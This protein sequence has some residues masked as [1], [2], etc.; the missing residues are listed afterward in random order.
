MSHFYVV[1]KK[2]DNSRVVRAAQPE[3]ARE[4][5]RCVAAGGLLAAVMFLYAWQHFQSIQLSYRL[6][7]LKAKQAEAAELNRQLTLEV[8]SLRSPARIDQ[9]ARQLGLRV[10][11]PDQLAPM[12]PKR[13]AIFAQARTE[14]LPSR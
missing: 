1:S 5:L 6:E 9:I 8:A 7:S 11:G 12:E 10:P 14:S 13:E 2:I 4:M 3:H